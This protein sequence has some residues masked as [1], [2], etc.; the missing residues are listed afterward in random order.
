MF[1]IDTEE[2]ISKYCTQNF[3]EKKIWIEN[4]GYTNFFLGKFTIEMNFDELYSLNKLRQNFKPSMKN[5]IH[6]LELEYLVN[7]WLENY[8]NRKNHKKIKNR[9]DQLTK[10]IS[11]QKKY[12]P[13]K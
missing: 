11:L 2:F 13:I 5:E 3:V 6:K 12:E 1:G 7:S 8:A 10:I 9:I 4:I